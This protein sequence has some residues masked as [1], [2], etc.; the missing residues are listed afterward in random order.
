M[1][2]DAMSLADYLAKNYLTV[3]SNPERRP[4]KR[5]RKDGGQSGII[6]ADDDALGWGA[7]AMAADENDGPLNGKLSIVLRLLQRLT[8]PPVGATSTEFRRTKNNN[9][10]TV[11][12][13][14]P[15]AA[16]QAAA[17]AIIAS[18]AAETRSR[19]LLDGEGPTIDDDGQKME[20]GAQAG[21]Q[22]A[23][24]VT[25]QLKRKQEAEHNRFLA[26]GM[27][28]SGRGTETIYRDASGRIINVAMKRAEARKKAEEE[29]AKTAAQLEAQKGDFQRAE[30]ERRREALKEAKFMPVA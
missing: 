5:K 4:R 12:A 8:N 7:K 19:M 28:R 18:A 11:G 22:T 13:P 1:T 17:D 3:D 24:Q 23:D 9:W 15:S 25:A 10:Q 30:R 2:I 26:E 16:D 21:L 29:A 20:S 6:I 14:T 27:E